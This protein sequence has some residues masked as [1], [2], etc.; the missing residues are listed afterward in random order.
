MKRPLSTLLIL[1]L[2]LCPVLSFAVGTT[3]V[4]TP[5]KIQVLGNQKKVVTVTITA[6]ASTG[7]IANGTLNAATL[8]LEGWYLYTVETDPGSTAPQALY[9]LVINDANG[10]DVAGGLLANRSATVTELV[11]IGTASHGFPVMRGNWT[12]VGTG[13]N[14]N[15]ATVVLYLTFV[16]E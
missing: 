16:P 4:T 7:A 6:D 2:V 9:D 11:N 3:T 12:I 15:N 5:Q 13:N 8:G 14:V 1:G 10:F